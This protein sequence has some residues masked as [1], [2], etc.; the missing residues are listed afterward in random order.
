MINDHLDIAENNIL[1]IGNRSYKNLWDELILLWTVKL[2]LKE[3]KEILIACYDPKWLQHFL[4]QFIDT[5]RITFL[6]EIPKWP[7]SLVKYIGEKKRKERKL[8]KKADA[9]IIGGGE[10]LTEENRNSYR[11]R[12][13]SVLP[14][15]F[16]KIPIYLMWGI[17]VPRK[18]IN[19]S[20][21][22]I[23]LNKTKKIFARDFDSVNELKHFWF[24]NTEFFMD[25]AFFAYER[26]KFLS[27]NPSKDALHAHD[28][29][30]SPHQSS[31]DALHASPRSE[32]TTCGY[33]IVNVNKNGEKFF[34]AIFQDVKAY[35]QQGYEVYFV[36]VSIGTQKD[37]SDIFY[38]YKLKNSLKHSASSLKLVR[39]ESDFKHFAEKVANAEIVI[40]TRL[41]LFLIASFLQV[42][43][44]VYPYQKKILKMQHTWWVLSPE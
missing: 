7:R 24:E 33:I 29:P 44:K 28:K 27:H 38:Y 39:R 19:K 20:L 35:I 4:A 25:T 10:I 17:Q 37:Y 14:C 34:D 23:L 8:R 13:V 9:I 42:K 43:T 11:Y 26:K 21:F 32:T 36:P 6:T 22:K 5:S 1:I 40:S 16:K 12:L 2:L 15:W 3:R 41:H 18:N 31:K 30:L